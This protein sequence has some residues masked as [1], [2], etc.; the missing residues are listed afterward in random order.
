MLK[1]RLLGILLVPIKG[2]QRARY[3]KRNGDGKGRGV[4]VE[5]AAEKTCVDFDVPFNNDGTTI[6]ACMLALADRLTEEGTSLPVWVLN[7]QEDSSKFDRWRVP[8]AQRTSN[9]GRDRRGYGHNEPNLGQH[10]ET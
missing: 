5:N 1:T 2:A 6:C 9:Q 4:G 10:W 7:I 3:R 8:V